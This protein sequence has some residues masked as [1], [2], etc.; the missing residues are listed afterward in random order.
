MFGTL[1]TVRMLFEAFPTQL[2]GQIQA[3]FYLGFAAGTLFGAPVVEQVGHI[4]AFAV[5]AAVMASS[6]LGH[7]LFVDAFFWAVLR[8]IEGFSLA[9]LFMVTESW[10]NAKTSSALR[11][12]VFSFYMIIN[13]TCLGIGQIFLNFADPQG[14][15]LFSLGAM[16]FALSLVPIALTRG[17]TPADLPLPEPALHTPVRF[18]FGQLYSLSPLGVASCLAAGLLTSAFFAMGPI[19]AAPDSFSVSSLAFFM[20]GAIFSGLLAQWP[21]GVIAD[22]YDRRKV[23]LAVALLATLVNGLIVGFNVVA[24]GWFLLLIYSSTGLVFTLYGLGAAHA[25]DAIH[26]EQTVAASAGLLLAFGIGASIGPL[27]AAALMERFGR[28]GLFGFFALITL[29]L[30][31]FAMHRMVRG[32]PISAEDK[33]AFVSIPVTTTP[34][35]ANLDP[36]SEPAQ[37]D[38]DLAE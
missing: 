27:G 5:F 8:T 32:M 15:Q 34:S 29:T 12:Q 10:L 23:I 22:R 14:F 26:P 19:Y 11:G 2:I 25:N 35:L 4:R 13:Y 31:M 18:G 3:A 16:L 9:G 30:V 38:L 33:T 36:R 17:E 37:G 7:A 24:S 20:S 6:V 1:L 28:N 21:L